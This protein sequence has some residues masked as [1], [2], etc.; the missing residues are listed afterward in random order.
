MG[1]IPSSPQC[2]LPDHIA[3]D[4]LRRY[5]DVLRVGRLTVNGRE[6]TWGTNASTAG[7]L[8]S[9]CASLHASLEQLPEAKGLDDA[10]LCKMPYWLC[11]ALSINYALSEVLH[12]LSRKVGALCCI[13]DGRSEPVD[14]GVDLAR[15]QLEKGCRHILGASLDWRGR[16]NIVCRDPSTAA[17]SVKGTLSR[18]STQF[19]LPPSQD[20][21]PKYTLQLQLRR[22]FTSRLLSTITCAKPCTETCVCG[23]LPC[24]DGLV[25][26]QDE[27][28]LKADSPLRDPGNDDDDSALSGHNWRLG[29]C[30]AGPFNCEQQP[31]SIG[32]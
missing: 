4:L 32:A 27:L 24:H 18:L 21:A 8:Q 10:V 3:K 15:I 19:P 30:P 6:V 20:F 14:Y 25:A 17:R 22:S 23:A 1:T 29:V 7:Q 13:E 9:F 31:R 5:A 26:E 11:K 28:C 2:G 16:D 12:L